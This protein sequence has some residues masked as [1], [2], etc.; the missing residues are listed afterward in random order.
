MGCM[1]VDVLRPERACG[2][3]VVV[4]AGSSGRV[5][6]QRAGLLARHGALAAPVRWFGGPG[7]QPGPWEVPIEVVIGA[8]DAVAP[9]VDRLA[10][11]GV[12]FGAEAALVAGALDERVDRV[13][14]FAPTSVMWSA[15][16]EVRQR[17]TSKWTHQGEPL[18][19]L[20]IERPPGPRPPGPPRHQETY[21][22]SLALADPHLIERATIPVER[23][24]EV[25]LVSG[26]DD[27][28]WP[29]AGLARRIEER[30]QR[31]GL[32]TTHIT[33][34]EAGHRTLLPGESAPRGG[35]VM[36]RG[37]TPEA[38]A[39]L[40]R[41]AWPHLRHLLGLHECA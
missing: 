34:P 39:E 4:L 18:A 29:A 23:I 14:A 31:H 36:A 8:L 11:L 3:G 33:L 25:L 30:R 12:S 26:G 10:I 38:D 15:Y 32:R 22:H 35:A 17:R 6:R 41:R 16:D 27:Q 13:A 20:P 19:G 5:D 40:G 9:E 2:T 28:V 37:G 7:Q 1:P 21:E 24:A